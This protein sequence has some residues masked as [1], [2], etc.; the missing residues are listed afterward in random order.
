MENDMVLSWRVIGDV[1]G[2]VIPIK[3]KHIFWSGVI[4][5]CYTSRRDIYYSIYWYWKNYVA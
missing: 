5:K 3:I 1:M 4:Y 2:I